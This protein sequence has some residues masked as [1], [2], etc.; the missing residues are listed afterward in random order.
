MKIFV[1]LGRFLSNFLYRFLI[2]HRNFHLWV[3]CWMDRKD[4]GPEMNG[5]QVL[6]PTP[7]HRSGGVWLILSVLL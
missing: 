3:E 2:Y 5:W 4:L 7:Q 1:F 6:D